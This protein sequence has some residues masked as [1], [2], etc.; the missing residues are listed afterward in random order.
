MGSSF[1]SHWLAVF[2]SLQQQYWVKT[3]SRKKFNLKRRLPFRDTQN[4]RLAQIV[5]HVCGLLD[6][7]R[8][9]KKLRDTQSIRIFMIM[10]S[11][12]ILVVK[13]IL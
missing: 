3:C 13:Y 2:L 11:H 1:D 5:W 6:C 7:R 12:N 8:T 9:S 10:K 4:F